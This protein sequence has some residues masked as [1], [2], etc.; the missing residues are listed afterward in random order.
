MVSIMHPNVIA[1]EKI[2]LQHSRKSRI[3]ILSR[4]D[5]TDKVVFKFDIF[6]QES[7]FHTQACNSFQAAA[8]SHW[9]QKVRWLSI[10][11]KSGLKT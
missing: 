8:V 6:R 10:K 5:N 1:W 2:L 7:S 11:L 3:G 9:P 4:A